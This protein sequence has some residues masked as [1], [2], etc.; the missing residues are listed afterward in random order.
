MVGTP[1]HVETFSKPLIGFNS[2]AVALSAEPMTDISTLEGLATHKAYKV[3]D[4]TKQ[5]WAIDSVMSF[6]DSAS[7]VAASNVASIDRLGGLV[8][9]TVALATGTTVTMTSAAPSG[10]PGSYKHGYVPMYFLSGGRAF[11]NTDQ[12][13]EIDTTATG[14]AFMTGA[15]NRRKITGAFQFIPGALI[16][17][18][19]GTTLM[20][21]EMILAEKKNNNGI[22]IVIINDTVNPNQPREAAFAYIGN[23]DKTRA[24][25]AVQERAVT[26]Y[27]MICSDSDSYKYITLLA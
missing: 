12:S 13:T 25:G 24:M 1:R 10:A 23:F 4:R 11:S 16:T 7:P 21:E 8:F 2:E 20:I 17:N 22:V 27:L 15:P 9:F 18:Q 5:Y 19:A 26:W 3:T 6:L 14:D